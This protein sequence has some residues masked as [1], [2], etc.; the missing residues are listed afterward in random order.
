M[1]QTWKNFMSLYLNYRKKQE[2]ADYKASIKKV[3][4]FYSDLQNSGEK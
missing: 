4:K 1:E 2:E 3:N